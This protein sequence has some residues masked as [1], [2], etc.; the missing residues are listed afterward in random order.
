[1][2]HLRLYCM[3]ALVVAAFVSIAAYAL[4]PELDR[5]YYADNTFTGDIV[6]EYYRTCEGHITRWGIT[7]NYYQ[8]ETFG[9]ET[10]GYT[11]EQCIIIDGFAD[12]W[13]C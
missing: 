5:T 7:T 1:M 2:N 6:G 8:D 13:G 4:G 3:A 12:C 11:C 10:F 9:C